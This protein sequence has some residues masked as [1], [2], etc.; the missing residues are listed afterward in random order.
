MSRLA[1]RGGANEDGIANDVAALSLDGFGTPRFS[2]YI[3]PQSPG[4]IPVEDDSEDSATEQCDQDEEDMHAQGIP[5]ARGW[6]LDPRRADQPQ[7]RKAV[8]EMFSEVLRLD[9]W[10]TEAVDPSLLPLN[11]DN[12]RLKRISGAMTNAV[13]FVSYVPEGVTLPLPPKVLLRV[14]GFGS[15]ALLSRR[16]E[17]LILHTLS[18]LYEIGPHIM[19]TFANGRVEE[20]YDCEPIGCEGMRDF[21][22][23]SEGPA[24]WVARR[25][26]ELHEVPLDVMKTVL[27]QGDL[28]AP[29]EKGF[30]R[31]IENHIMASAHRPK[32]RT[33]PPRG[34][35]G[36]VM[37]PHVQSYSYFAH[38][39]PGL[40]KQ[41][42]SSAMS[43]DSL[44]TSYDSHCYSSDSSGTAFQNMTPYM[45]ATPNTRN[46]YT[47]S[48]FT[49]VSQDICMSPLALGPSSDNSVPTQIRGPYPGVWRRMKRW[50]REASKVIELV[51][52]FLET[53]EGKAVCTKLD[54]PS[55]L[56]VIPNSPEN[57]PIV[58]S[59]ELGHTRF[60]FSDMLK[61]LLAFDLPSLCMQV[62]QYKW[63]VRQWERQNGKS[64]RVF[65]H[66]DSQYGNLLLR[67]FN[68]H[69]QLPPVAAGM[70]RASSQV[71]SRSRRRDPRNMPHQRLVVIDFEYASPNPRAYDI[72]NHFHEWR[73]NYHDL[74][75]P[76]SLVDHGAYPNADERRRWLHSYV[77]QGLA[78]GSHP[79][80]P[81]KLSGSDLA[82]VP[83]ME[84][85]AAVLSTERRTEPNTER[86]RSV[87]SPRVFS[88]SSPASHALLA[89][90]EQVIN[91]EIERLEEE[92]SIWSPATH[93]IWGLW[94]VVIAREDIIALIESARSHVHLRGDKLVYEPPE[95]AEKQVFEA[96]SAESFDNLR[97][98]LGRI[99]LM[100]AE[101]AALN[102]TP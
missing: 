20:Y 56:P 97:Y 52:E 3:N 38:P 61:S 96:G 16:T 11:P 73:A 55:S 89:Q 33:R 6:R 4:Q 67:R 45:L 62:V 91:A 35:T 47:P 32:R 85:P 9:G 99:E 98:A 43:F 49:N 78:I 40:F 7:F 25:M 19:G 58:T 26:R 24:H 69:G 63:H 15:E 5:A 84:L 51:N 54:L 1:E 92:I 46:S 39:S 94:G 27:E 44:A 14:Y 37:S 100:R 82:S 12:V 57:P 65:C 76:W 2:P 8:L 83:E 66:N 101:L 48:Q 23:N 80:S 13:F 75:R 93:I 42:N 87:N 88:G 74:E 41:S 79:S 21:G 90:R 64:R 36:D 29:S 102:I 77:E 95:A 81:A 28:H 59:H 50:T 68:E 17:L 71:D 10:T 72:A 60:S 30:G 31:G 18:S 86:R 70:R 22:S 34:D 53:P